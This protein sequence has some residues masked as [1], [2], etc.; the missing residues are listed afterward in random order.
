MYLNLAPFLVSCVF[1]SQIISLSESL[2]L[3]EEIEKLI[4][5]YQNYGV[6]SHM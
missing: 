2:I 4:S 3:S 5:T 6:K 1:F